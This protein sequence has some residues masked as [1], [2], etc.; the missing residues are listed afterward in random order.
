MNTVFSPVFL[1]VRILGWNLSK[2]EK[3]R[4][5]FSVGSVYMDAP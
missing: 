1:T 3:L 4:E 2:V 5:G